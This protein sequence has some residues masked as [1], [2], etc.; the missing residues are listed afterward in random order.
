[1]P[2]VVVFVAVLSLPVWA[3]AQQAPAQLP[4]VEFNVEVLGN[5]LGDFTAKMDAYA[6]LRRSLEEGLPALTVT[7]RPVEIRQAEQLLAQRIREARAGTGRGDIF[8]EDIRR[9][10][11]QLLRPVTNAATCEVIRDDNPGEFA[12]AVNSDYPKNKPVSSVPA[13]MLAVLPRLPEDVWYRF[14][15][16]DLILH[17]SRANVILDRIDD[18]VR[19]EK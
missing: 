8:T 11:K 9:G 15:D 1:M 7:D 14:L 4:V 2:L 17:D 10:F 5:A 6:A 19:C 18:A 13:A 12:Y 3:F 16:R